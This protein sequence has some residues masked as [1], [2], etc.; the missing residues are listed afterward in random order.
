MLI[1]GQLGVHPP[2][3]LGV[4]FFVHARAENLI[5]RSGDG[6]TEHL[7]EAGCVSIEDGD[8]QRVVPLGG[9]IHANL[10]EADAKDALPELLLVCCN[11]N[12]LAEFTGEMTRFLESLAERGR[13]STP[14]AV[15]EG[16]P[17]LLI[18]PNGV[19]FESTVNAFRDQTNESILM[20][21][22]PGVTPEV[23]AAI[24]DR[25]VRGISLQAGGRRGCG[26][27]TV[28]L[29]E[30]KGALLF[31]GGGADE[32]ER[33]ARI[34]A[35]HDYPFTHVEGVP[36]TRVEFDKAMI[37]IVL[38]VGGLIHTVK[39]DGELHRP[40]D[41]RPLQATP[42]GPSFVATGS[43]VPCSTSARRSAPTRAR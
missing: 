30:R 21:R 18:L 19:L 39:P 38:N 10:L 32:G 13:L 12:Q 15:R 14:R 42:P 7:K 11:P 37:S 3:A 6:I 16:M 20:D 36:A 17:I 40:A 33:I 43:P 2:G 5:G 22:L 41:G 35:E 25:V 34:L 31:A 23:E 24:V 9:R 4:G 29:L 26:P 1:T 28:Y 8:E 27:D